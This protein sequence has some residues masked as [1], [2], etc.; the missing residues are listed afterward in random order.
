[1]NAD[2]MSNEEA[3]RVLSDVLD[4]YLAPGVLTAAA[5]QRAHRALD[6]LSITTPPAEQGARED[7]LCAA[8]GKT[9]DGHIGNTGCVYPCWKPSG[10]FKPAPQWLQR[11]RAIEAERERAAEARKLATAKPAPSV[12]ASEDDDARASALL[13][14]ARE[15]GLRGIMHGVSSSQAREALV[16]FVNAAGPRFAPLAAGRVGVAEEMVREAV[17]R[18]FCEIEPIHDEMVDAWVARVRSR[19]AESLAG[20]LVAGEV[21]AVAW[22]LSWGDGRFVRLYRTQ[23]EADADSATVIPTGRPFTIRPLVYADTAKGKRA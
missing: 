10:K 13:A 3:V 12:D 17:H 4:H 23:A 5:L 20:P 18:A 22:E 14:V 6:T 16:K 7:E 21:E 9:F 15:T 1:M 8:C 11:Q 2:T 19:A